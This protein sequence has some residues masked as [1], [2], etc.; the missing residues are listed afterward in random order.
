MGV[1][2][3]RYLPLHSTRRRLPPV[4]SLDRVLATDE[5]WDSAADRF[6]FFGATRSGVHTTQVLPG[7]V[8]A[9]TETGKHVGPPPDGLADFNGWCSEMGVTESLMKPVRE[10]FEAWH[11]VD[12]VPITFLVPRPS[13]C[14][15]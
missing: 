2:K 10:C 14:C 12:F 7:L 4:V 5:S 6:D 15:R 13:P 8:V 1:L 11:G 9:L 3:A